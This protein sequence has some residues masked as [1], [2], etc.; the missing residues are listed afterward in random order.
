MAVGFRPSTQPTAIIL[1][2]SARLVGPR[3]EILIIPQVVISQGVISQGV[4][5]QV[6][7]PQVVKDS[8]T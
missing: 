2:E 8:L 4:I 7:I 3:W 5:P 6:V 1:Y